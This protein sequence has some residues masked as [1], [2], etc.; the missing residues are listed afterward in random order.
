M[1]ER[2]HLNTFRFQIPGVAPFGHPLLPLAPRK[3]PLRIVCGAPLELPKISNPSEEDIST[4]HARYVA[5]L[6]ALYYRHVE[7]YH[8]DVYSKYVPNVENEKPRV[9]ERW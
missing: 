6:E 5:A 7:S 4:H 9:L 2:L 1:E 8:R 3:I